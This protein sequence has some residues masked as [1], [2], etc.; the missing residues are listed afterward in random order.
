M[1]HNNGIKGDGKKPPRLM[2]GVRQKMRIKKLLL[3]N[4]GPFRMYDIP[5]VDEEPACVL[6]TES[7]GEEACSGNG[8]G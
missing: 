3:E 6:L 5:F 2:P 7:I 8:Y 1:D 4:I